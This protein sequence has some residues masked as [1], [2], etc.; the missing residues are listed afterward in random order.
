MSEQYRTLYE[1]FITTVIDRK[2]DQAE[3]RIKEVLQADPNDSEALLCRSELLCIQGHTD[4][5]ITLTKQLLKKQ[6]RNPYFLLADAQ[7]HMHKAGLGELNL[8]HSDVEEMLGTAYAAAESYDELAKVGLVHCMH[9]FWSQG[10]RA[11]VDAAITISSANKDFKLMIPDVERLE[12][13]LDELKQMDQRADLKQIPIAVAVRAYFLLLQAND[14]GIAEAWL[15]AIK[16][17]HEHQGIGNSIAQPTIMP[18]LF[19]RYCKKK[20]FPKNRRPS[21]PRQ[22]NPRPRQLNH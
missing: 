21:Q 4:T 18:A 15:A 6:P 16:F 2:L 17:G 8:R 9:G 13:C 10:I 12:E 19:E 3:A 22:H 20:W 11:F 7:L 5:A 14:A 1:E